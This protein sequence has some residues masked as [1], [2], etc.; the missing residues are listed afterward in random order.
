[1]ETIVTF[2]VVFAL[3]PLFAIWF[4]DDVI[5][6]NERKLIP[7]VMM[8][9]PY[10]VKALATEWLML[11]SIFPIEKLNRHALRG[12]SIRFCEVRACIA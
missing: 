3:I 7:Y 4:A 11:M 9:N 8:A 12:Y 2:V 10:A 5:N 1:V 6:V